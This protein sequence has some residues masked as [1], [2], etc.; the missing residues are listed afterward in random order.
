VGAAAATPAFVPRPNG[1]P[2]HRSRNPRAT[3]L[4]QLLDTR[5]ET[6]KGLWEDHP[7]LTL[8]GSALLLYA[9][10]LR[11]NSKT[12]SVG[13]IP[14]KSRTAAEYNRLSVNFAVNHDF[15]SRERELAPDDEVAF[16]PPVSGG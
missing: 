9:K 6:L 11:P 4:Y 12:L 2:L 8:R 16:L 14:S 5:F 7:A 13:S 10:G 1:C 15:V 3:S